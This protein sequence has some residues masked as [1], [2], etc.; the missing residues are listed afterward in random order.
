MHIDTQ[1]QRHT[2]ILQHIKNSRQRKSTA[3]HAAYHTSKEETPN[4]HGFGARGSLS[5]PLLSAPCS[6]PHAA[7]A[8]VSGTPLCGVGTAVPGVCFDV[9]LLDGAIPPKDSS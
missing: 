6:A 4:S 7:S 8:G 1:I 9:P 5:L 3:Q 2:M